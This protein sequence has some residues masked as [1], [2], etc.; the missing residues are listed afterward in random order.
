M[1]ETPIESE[2]PI[3]ADGALMNAVLYVPK[4]CKEKYEAVDPWR[5]FYTIKEFDAVGSSNANVSDEPSVT[6]ED[7]TIKVKNIDGQTVSIY[8]VAGGLVLSVKADGS[9]IGMVLPDNGVYVV[10]VNDTETRI[11]L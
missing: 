4:G 3:F 11:N 9:S 5:N 2:E 8:D 6:V 10:K 1:M 7:G